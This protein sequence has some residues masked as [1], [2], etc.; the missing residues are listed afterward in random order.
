MQAIF[1][2]HGVTKPG[3]V[4]G[5]KGVRLT[6]EGC[7]QARVVAEALQAMG[8]Y[9]EVILT[10]PATR[11]FE[12]A[13]L[14]NSVESGAEIERMPALRHPANAMSLAQRLRELYE[15]EVQ[16]VAVIGHSPSLE[17]C[18]GQ[19][20]LGQDEAGIR[21]VPAG[22]ACVSLPPDDSKEPVRMLWLLTYEQLARIAGEA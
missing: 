7:E 19:L 16:T 21:L 4:G 15:A 9:V 13:S 20:V 2:R 5:D 17:G 10:S 6:E 14:I 22:A 18:I 1:I 12:T 11:A 8:L 3:G